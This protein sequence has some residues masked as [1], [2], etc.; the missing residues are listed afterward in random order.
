MG[1][2]DALHGGTLSTISLGGEAQFRLGIG[3]LPVDTHRVPPADP[4]RCPFRFMDRAG[5]CDLS[6]AH[7]LEH[8]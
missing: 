2:A 6:C 1:R 7:Y 4:Y 8:A 3:P 5:A